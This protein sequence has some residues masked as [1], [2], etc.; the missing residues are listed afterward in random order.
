M[1][2]FFSNAATNPGAPKYA[3]ILKHDSGKGLPVSNSVMPSSSI[4]GNSGNRSSPVTIAIFRSS[5]SF[6][7]VLSSIARQDI[8]LMPPAFVSIFIPFC[9]INGR[10]GS[11]C[12]KKSPAKPLSESFNFAL[13]KMDMVI[14]ARKSKT[15]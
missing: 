2:A 1:S 3:L 4:L 11:I 12:V 8:G 5:P 6:L 13:A 15:R 14:S 10:R 7:V 9:L